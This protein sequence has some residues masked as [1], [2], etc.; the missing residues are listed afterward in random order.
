[1]D[2]AGELRPILTELAGAGMSARQIAAELTARGISTSRGGRW[3][4]QTVL[5]ALELIAV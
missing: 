3:H 1:M 5:R 2:R 4:A